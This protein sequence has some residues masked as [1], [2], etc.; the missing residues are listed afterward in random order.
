MAAE[1]DLVGPT[2]EDQWRR[3]GFPAGAETGG[4]SGSWIAATDELEHSPD[5]ARALRTTGRNLSRRKAAL[6]PGGA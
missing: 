6:H 3:R 1:V 4:Y 2:L 5:G